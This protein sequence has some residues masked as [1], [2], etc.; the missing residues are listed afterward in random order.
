MS[1]LGGKGLFL[2]LIRTHFSVTSPERGCCIILD[3]GLL[4]KVEEPT[5]I[6]IELDRSVYVL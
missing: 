6:K 4:K 2:I 1:Q 5:T 3:G